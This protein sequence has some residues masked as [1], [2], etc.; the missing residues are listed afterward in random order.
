MKKDIRGMSRREELRRL[1][2]LTEP[3]RL[4][5][6]VKNARMYSKKKAKKAKDSDEIQK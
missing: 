6:K 1:D 3:P 5:G 2:H 4:E